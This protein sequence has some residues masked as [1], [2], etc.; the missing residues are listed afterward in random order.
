MT[1]TEKTITEVRYEGA[2]SSEQF[3]TLDP[4]AQ[5]MHGVRT[6][7]SE[8][9]YPKGWFT[10]SQKRLDYEKKY[11]KVK[12]GTMDREGVLE[13]LNNTYGPESGAIPG[14]FK[15][16]EVTTTTHIVHSRTEDAD[17][18]LTEDR[19]E[20]VTTTAEVFHIFKRTF[21][22]WKQFTYAPRQEMREQQERWRIQNETKR[23][24]EQ[25]TR[26][27]NRS[28]NALVDGTDKQT[29]KAS[30]EPQKFVMEPIIITR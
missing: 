28:F 1:T 3:V 27:A 19:Q 10:I 29:D 12:L 8:Y 16:R 4:E 2:T 9:T 11:N 30:S 13:Y 23:A 14:S 17:G 21:E 25:E 15:V 18:N 5:G 26:E 20:H 7:D 6:G 24:A 22:D